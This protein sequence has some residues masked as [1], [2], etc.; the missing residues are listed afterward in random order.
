MIIHHTTPQ[1]IIEEF[2]KIVEGIDKDETEDDYAWWENSVGAEFGIK[3]KLELKTLLISTVIKQ[4]EEMLNK[5]D[6]INPRNKKKGY[7]G[8]NL[9]SACDYYGIAADSW[10]E[11]IRYEHGQ[12]HIISELRL[13]LQSKIKEWKLIE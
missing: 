13:S 11:I 8:N 7:D 12:D 2:E 6:I 4:Y 5:V 1:E 10:A 9:G 3:K